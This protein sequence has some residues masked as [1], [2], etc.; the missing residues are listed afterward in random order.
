MKSNHLKTLAATCVLALALP[1]SSTAYAGK[2]TAGVQERNVR[3]QMYFL[4]GDAMQGRGSGTPFERV[5]A[6][7][8]GSQFMQFGLTPAGDKDTVGQASFVQTVPVAGKK[9]LEQLQMS[10][11][12]GSG[13]EWKRNLNAVSVSDTTVQGPL[14]IVK[15]GDAVKPGAVAYLEVAD[16][17]AFSNIYG[18]FRQLT[19]AGAKAVIVRANATV[20]KAWADLGAR[21]VEAGREGN[22]FVV[23]EAL[24][25]TLA[26]MKPGQE[27][28]FAGNFKQLPD[29]STWN[30]I[31]KIEGSDPKLSAQT[32]VLSSHLDHLGVSGKADAADRINNGAD[33]DAS[34]T[35]AVLELARALSSGAR[36]KRTI[37]FVAFGSEEAGGYGS[38]HFLK[39]L[40][41]AH[42]N[43]I[44][45]LQFEM[46]GRPD[47][48]VP[49]QTLWL[50]GYDRSNLGPELARR[51][52][53]L[54]ADP[55]LEE[56]FF[57][58]SDNYTFA[59]QGIIA[60]TV[61]SYGLHQD[62]HHA[63]DENGKI[64]FVHMTRS[65]ESMVAPVR[66]LA[67]STFMPA[68]NAGKKP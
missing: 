53:R 39:T 49:A 51:G 59:R 15:T 10:G 31:G 28:A 20:R 32:I 8:V 34:G 27:I 4:A 3:A 16:D 50:T 7:Y 56:N 47:D 21:E 6:E 66:W 63:S 18:A 29:T 41:F 17:M 24:G 23:D 35:V 33:D 62:Y 30:A 19:A 67:G 26:A 11:V 60:H 57:Q 5:A 58:R 45:N 61:S 46:I 38:K 37:Y 40:P 1:L 9:V 48:T 52:A 22:L 2:A 36:P 12:A 42:E 65:I 25:K 68:W 64:D 55:H 43:F 14:Q 54:V 44:A 13:V